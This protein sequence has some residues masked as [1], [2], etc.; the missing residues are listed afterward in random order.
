MARADYRREEERRYSGRKRKKKNKGGKIA[1]AAVLLAAA[2][3]IVGIV[4]IVDINR[5]RTGNEKEDKTVKITLSDSETFDT[6]TDKLVEAGVVRYKIAYDWVCMRYDFS[7]GFRSGEIELRTSM[8]YAEIYEAIVNHEVRTRETVTV[9]FPEGSEVADIVAKFVENGIGTKEG[10]AKVIAEGDFGY[11]Y[12]PEKNKENRLEGFLY[13]DTYEFYTDATEKEALQ[14][15]I[16]NFNGKVMTDEVRE[17]LKSSKYGLYEIVT[18]AS[19]IEKEGGG[20]DYI[21][22]IS[23]VFH[24]RLDAGIKLQSDACYSYRLPKSERAY[25]LTYAQINTDDPYNTYFYKGL[26]PTPICN[27]TA[28]CVLA[29]L[30][31]ADTD[32]FYFCYVGDG[33]TKFARTLAEHERNAAEFN[34]WRKNHS[35]G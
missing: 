34:E 9:R 6:I 5:D 21:D 32:Y 14:K 24:N 23:S 4:F 22:K 10:F 8:S 25:S 3:V 7:K 35:N 29:A 17:L 20:Y 31:P 12:I 2:L 13:P 26:T 18:L 33:V 30:K 11:D 27:P 15:L 28:S 16:D 1:L 19:I